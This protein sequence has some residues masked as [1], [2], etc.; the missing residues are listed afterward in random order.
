[1]KKR[2]ANLFAILLMAFVAPTA[3]VNGNFDPALDTEIEARVL[4]LH[5]S[6]SL[7]YD[8]RVSKRIYQYCHKSKDI[9]GIMLGRVSMYFPLIE[10]ELKKRNLPNDLKYLTIIESGLKPHATSRVGAAGLWQFM[11]RTARGQGLKVTSTIDE[12]RDVHKS[13]SAALDYLEE[14]HGR[15]GD[16]TL[17]L[18]A[19]NCGPGNV[20]KAIRRSGGKTDF[21]D[22]LPY[23]PKETRNYI[24]K[25]IAMSYTMQ[26]YYMHD[27]S[28]QYVDSDLVYTA[29]AKVFDRVS[30]K[31]IADKYE[32]DLQTVKLL[33]PAYIRGYIPQ[34]KSGRYSITLPQHHLYDYVANV[35]SFDDV[36]YVYGEQPAKHD[37]PKVDEVATAQ[38]EANDSQ[39]SREMLT[40]PS[41][42]YIRRAKMV[43][44]RKKQ[45]RTRRDEVAKSMVGYIEI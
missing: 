21:W 44:Q 17:A 38:K 28:P 32:I 11:R 3:D 36:F 10:E 8:S 12:R 15:F 26:Y 22:I 5:S 13:T 23:L 40:P 6:V 9:S 43:S 19:Y 33:N 29:S 30:L 16:W 1:M 2:I 41:K 45:K 27:I 20:R 37:N 39:V 34:N 18:A 14:L 24:P 4:S 31:D 35:G 25:F 7:R 42:V